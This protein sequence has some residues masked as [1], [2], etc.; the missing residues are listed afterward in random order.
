MNKCALV[1]LLLIQMPVA[2]A[3]VLVFG[4]VP[5]QSASRLA[6]QWGPVVSELSHSTGYE[7][8]FSTAPNIPEF[9]KRLSAGE[10]DL[11]YMNPYHYTVYSQSPGYQAVA[12]AR[13][14][15]I[16]GIIVARKANQ[17]ESLDALQGEGLAFPSPAA[18]AATLLTQSDL[19]QAGIAFDADYVSSHDSVYL[20]VARG[21]YPAGGGILRTFNSLPKE[22]KSQ[23]EP[24]WITK[25]YTPHA[26]ATHPRLTRMQVESLQRAL[27]ELEQTSVGQEQLRL[28]NL[29][30][31]EVAVDSDWDDVRA[32][33]IT[34]LE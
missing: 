7:I 33:N 4:V 3:D 31:F 11:A 21:F 19:R 12:K 25:A 1:V 14:K 34:L 17:F 8:V 22:V 23:L 13:D 5:Q 10:Y 26:I 15:Q 18:F 30:G 29:K 27:T 16:K 2:L 9:E 28:L 24:I 32:L 20:S 6:Q